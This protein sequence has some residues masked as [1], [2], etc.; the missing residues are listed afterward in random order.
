MIIHI[1]R[2][3]MKMARDILNDEQVEREI[4]RLQAS[5]YVKL[6]AKERAIKYKRRRYLYNLR[7]MEK[8]GKALEEAG[9]T[10]EMLETLDSATPSGDEL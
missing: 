7:L 5:P 2:K 1:F 4:E 9:I 8:H 3:E 10:M 6:S